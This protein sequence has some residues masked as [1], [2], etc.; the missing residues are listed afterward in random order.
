MK[1]HGTKARTQ[2][3]L[4]LMR[5]AIESVKKITTALIF[6]PA[7]RRRNILPEIRSRP[8]SKKRGAVSSGN[9]SILRRAVADDQYTSP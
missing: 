5:K 4:N 8:L 1:S 2:A 7:N 3:D 9:A 6:I